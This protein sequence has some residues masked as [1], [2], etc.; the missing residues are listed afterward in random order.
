MLTTIMENPALVVPLLLSLLG[1]FSA[2]A[3]FTPNDSDNKIAAK[4]WKWVNNLGLRGGP[5]D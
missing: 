1:V 4:M 5:T 3:R 2:I